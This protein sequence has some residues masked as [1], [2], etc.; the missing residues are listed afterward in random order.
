MN[1]LQNELNTMLKTFDDKPTIKLPQSIPQQETIKKEAILESIETALV[2]A[3]KRNFDSAENVKVTMDRETGEIHV[4]A[5]KDVV[6]KPEDIENSKLQ[7]C[8]EDAK[9]IN[10]NL[11]VGDKAEIEQVQKEINENKQVLLEYI[12]HIYKKSNLL[13]T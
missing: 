7:I 9:S 8:L 1:N 10:K 4:Y 2:T 3:Y 5:E 11:Q 12:S 13:N 6:E